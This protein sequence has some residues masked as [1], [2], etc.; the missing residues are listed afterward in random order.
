M[1]LSDDKGDNPPSKQPCISLHLSNP[2]VRAF[3]G[4][5]VLGRGTNA[6]YKSDCTLELP[7]L[8]APISPEP[9]CIPPEV[10][11]CIDVSN[12]TICRRLHSRHSAHFNRVRSSPIS[13]I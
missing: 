1:D 6:L 5:V 3:P 11:L 4:I 13:Y 2:S 12:K 9:P 7:S 10:A 8:Q